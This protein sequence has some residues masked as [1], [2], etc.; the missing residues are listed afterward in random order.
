[1]AATT[2]D[3]SPE[4]NAE[5]FRQTTESLDLSCLP[6]FAGANNHITRPIVIAGD[7]LN[8]ATIDCAGGSIG[9]GDARVFTIRSSTDLVP[10]VNQYGHFEH[11]FS[12]IEFLKTSQWKLP[13]NI[14]IKNCQINGGV[15][16]YGAGRN[17][18]AETVKLSSHHLDHT[19]RLR[20][21]AP[22]DIFFENIEFSVSGST[23]VYISP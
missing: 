18:Q 6:V 9:D 11:I 14:T 1:M 13:Q 2:L 23:S 22:R 8:G 10:A 21:I 7:Q 16:I 5:V 12:D 20:T 15:R 3:C 17:G 19:A 4:Q